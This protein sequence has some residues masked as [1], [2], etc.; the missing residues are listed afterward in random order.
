MEEDTIGL[1]REL[2]AEGFTT[3]SKCGRPLGRRE[4]TP[5]PSDGLP[6]RR[7]IEAELCS[8]CRDDL[9]RGDTD[10]REPIE[11]P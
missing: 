8:S 6:E 11:E 3:C 7:S 4:A 1:T 10:L 9:A 2:G 5:L